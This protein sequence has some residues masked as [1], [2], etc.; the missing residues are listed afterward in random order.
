MNNRR[1]AISFTKVCIKTSKSLECQ[2]CHKYDS[3]FVCSLCK[4]LAC[5]WDVHISKKDTF[6]KICMLDDTNAQYI[7]PI[8]INNNK[9]CSIINY[10][11]GINLFKNN[12]IYP[13]QP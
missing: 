10:M 6:C 4:R 2:I 8:L 11:F 1:S 7:I 3:L 13:I 12:R 9:K 5:A